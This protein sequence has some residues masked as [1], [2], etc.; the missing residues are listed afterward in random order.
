MLYCH[1]LISDYAKFLFLI[2]TCFLHNIQVRTNKKE[3]NK[4]VD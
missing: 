1:H 3:L 2:V 4:V